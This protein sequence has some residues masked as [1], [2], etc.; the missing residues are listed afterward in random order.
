M[1]MPLFIP[2]S[3]VSLRMQ[4]QDTLP[5]V[6]DAIASAIQGAEL[7]IEAQLGSKLTYR[8]VDCRFFLDRTAFSGMQPGGLFRLE[9]P[10]G[11]VRTDEQMTVTYDSRWNLPFAEPVDPTLMVLDDSRGYLLVDACQ[12]AN[13]YV[14]VQCSTGYKDSVPTPS[15]TGTAAPYNNATTYSPGTAVTIVV[16]GQT[17]TYLCI[18]STT[19]NTP[20]NATYWTLVTFAPEAIPDDLAE[21]ILSYVPSIFDATQNTNR[22]PQAQPQYKKAAEMAYLLLKPYL[23][24]EGFSLRPFMVTVG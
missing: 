9:I 22:D 21:A 8:N 7:Q 16:N 24:F 5:G 17:V 14:R 23:R 12:Y 20:P 4:L 19:G 18:A 13:K 2:A 6:T 11:F 15:F 10:S 1:A 3:A